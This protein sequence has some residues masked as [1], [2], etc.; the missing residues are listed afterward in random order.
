TK[1]SPA[2]LCVALAATAESTRAHAQRLRRMPFI[3]VTKY[4]NSKA[5]PAR[6]PDRSAG[7]EHRWPVCRA[8][9]SRLGRA[10]AAP[11]AGRYLRPLLSPPGPHRTTMLQISRTTRASGAK[12]L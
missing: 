11:G 7:R 5:C 9:G 4:G 1:I 2:S 6:P 3:T 10:E 8:P 12:D